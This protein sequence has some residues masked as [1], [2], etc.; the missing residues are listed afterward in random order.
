MDSFKKYVVVYLSAF[1]HFN[2]L[3]GDFSTIRPNSQCIS[4]FTALSSTRDN[5]LPAG[6]TKFENTL[7][8]PIRQPISPYDFKPN[9]VSKTSNPD[10]VDV[11]SMLVKPG[12]IL[13]RRPAGIADIVKTLSSGTVEEIAKLAEGEPIEIVG[14]VGGN[15]ILRYEVRGGHHRLL[16]LYKYLQ[17]NGEPT[18]MAS[19]RKIHPDL[20]VYSQEIF[21]ISK[22]SKIPV[23]GVL[24]ETLSAKIDLYDSLKAPTFVVRG[25]NYEVGS[26]TTL[27]K[28]AQL[29]HR[30][31]NS[32]AKVR[33]H[34]VR[35]A[36]IPSVEKLKLLEQHAIDSGLSDIVLVSFDALVT[37]RLIELLPEFEHLNLYLGDLSG[38][39]LYISRLKNTDFDGFIKLRLGQIY[40]STQVYRLEG[41]DL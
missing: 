18:T 23:H 22:K 21:N 13:L 1:I 24:F 26:R 11:G 14:V 28:V 5:D 29:L 4:P 25:S 6:Y 20:V 35:G 16:G 34:L 10:S 15:S 36:E 33:Y 3:G 8:K 19:I 41:F 17:Q 30:P 38:E 2:L 39:R 12:H 7:F 37:K 32:H 40:L 9:H 31:E 27:A